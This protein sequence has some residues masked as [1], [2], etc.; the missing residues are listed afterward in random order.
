VTI[1]MTTRDPRHHALALTL[2]VACGFFA[3]GA[4]RADSARQVAGGHTPARIV[5]LVPAATEMLFGVG[6]GP[7]VVGV[8]SFDTYPPE[9]ASRTRVGALV[10][11]DLERILSLRPDLVVVFDSQ[12]ELQQQLARAGIARFVYRHGG[13]ADVMATIRELGTRV[14]RQ[15]E[16]DALARTLETRIA[17]VRQ[18]V[19]G[20]PRPSTLLVFGRE[21]LALRN[22]FASGGVG[23]LNDI[24]VAAG[25][26][27]VF[28][29]V[30]RENV[31]AT[32]E[33]I[34]ARAPEVIVE[35][36]YG[37]P[38]SADALASERAVW[39][40]LGAVPAVRAGRVVMLVG[41]EFVVPGPRVAD[42]TERLARALHP[43]ANQ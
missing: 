43:E 15:G 7:R 28:A 41:D 6:A 21:P 30:K 35:L 25:G 18:R 1:E 11:P 4:R 29:D 17:A 26:A 10:D 12:Q 32:S 27:N 36:R 20:Q 42:A 34:L 3:A 14:G 39:N 40:T 2:V 8:S 31:Q 13:L 19:T 16:A 37:K 33:L 22:V 9:V 38:V 5:S 24:L 23:F